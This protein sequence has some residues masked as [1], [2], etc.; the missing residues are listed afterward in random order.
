[1]TPIRRLRSFQISAGVLSKNYS[2]QA[3]PHVLYFYTIS[4]PSKAFDR[5]ILVRKLINTQLLRPINRLEPKYHQNLVRIWK[6]LPISQF[7]APRKLKIQTI[8]V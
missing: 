6:N 4:Q 8:L 2:S 5:A 1:M 3:E 7:T